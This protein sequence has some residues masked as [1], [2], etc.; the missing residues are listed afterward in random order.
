V[1]NLINYW[2]P[3]SG[4]ADS[5]LTGLDSWKSR[6]GPKDAWYS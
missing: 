5:Y 1:G 3:K 4:S 2:Y 6:T